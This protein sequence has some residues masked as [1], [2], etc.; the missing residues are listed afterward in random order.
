[1]YAYEWWNARPDQII[2][3]IKCFIRI[4]E[5]TQSENYSAIYNGRHVYSTEFGI[6]TSGIYLFIYFPLKVPLSLAETSQILG[7]LGQ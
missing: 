1:M 7:I 2:E 6:S 3:L 5:D 4:C